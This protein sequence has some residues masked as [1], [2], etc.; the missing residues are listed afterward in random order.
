MYKSCGLKNDG[1]SCSQ[2]SGQN[3]KSKCS[4]NQLFDANK[5]KD[6][7]DV[8]DMCKYVS[9]NYSHSGN[10]KV[11]YKC[12]VGCNNGSGYVYSTYKHGLRST[13][14]SCESK[15]DSDSDSSSDI[16]DS[17]CESKHKVKQC[18]SD[19][20]SSSSDSDDECHK[21][22]TCHKK[23]P[24]KCEKKCEKK[25]DIV[26]NI[27]KTNIITPGTDVAPIYGHEAVTLLCDSIG[28]VF[29]TRIV[30][31]DHHTIVNKPFIYNFALN[32]NLGEL[33]VDNNCMATGRITDATDL[34]EHNNFWLLVL[35][36]PVQIL[37]T[38]T[39]DP[40]AT[41]TTADPNATTTVA[42][43]TLCPTTTPCPTTTA[44]PDAYKYSRSLVKVHYSSC[45]KKLIMLSKFDIPNPSEKRP[46][47]EGLVKLSCTEF[48][49]F[50]DDLSVLN[51]Q[52]VLYVSIKDCSAHV[53]EVAVKLCG[54]KLKRSKYDSLKVSTA[55]NVSSGVVF[56]P[57]YPEQH[58]DNVFHI[59]H[60][61]LDKLRKLADCKKSCLSV[62]ATTK[63]L[64]LTGNTAC[65]FPFATYKGI[66]AMTVSKCGHLIGLSAWLY[67]DLTATIPL[68]V[69]YD[70]L[71][72]NV[73]VTRP[74][75][76]KLI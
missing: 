45:D 10:K 50:S 4:K 47:F 64:C 18:D 1:C 11:D 33:N 73:T 41:T 19:S 8:C 9:Q 39:A 2:C 61:E 68:P 43:T 70:P 16:S 71:L 63:T 20:D 23:S 69:G 28:I 36:Q 17:E 75:V 42:P 54:H 46:N 35:D 15:C 66:E 29:P 74:I 30:A 32:L 67:S 76:G 72:A 27:C 56:V 38:T 59:S 58:C 52:G 26:A 65:D 12:P 60:C 13:I 5:P 37:P 53:H 25:Y 55:F 51:K 40:N 7:S 62:E 3:R 44:D 31:D 24:K 57:Q 49:L 6:C 14:K 34:D 22:K 21:K 48:L